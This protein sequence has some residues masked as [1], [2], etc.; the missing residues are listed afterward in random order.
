[1]RK[2]LLIAASALAASVISSQASVYSQNIVGYVNYPM[3]QGSHNYF[4]S[5]PFAIGV[6][7]GANEIFGT[8]PPSGSP[9]L[10]AGTAFYFY[11]GF[12]FD[13]ILYDVDPLG[14]GDTTD[15]WYMSNDSTPTNAPVLPVGMGFLMVPSG[16]ITNTWAGAVAINVGSQT[17]I[18]FPTGSKNYFVGCPVPYGGSLSNGLA[19]GGGP[20][21]NNLPLG[22]ALYFY[23]GF[24]FDETIYDND[25]LGTGDTDLWYMSNDSTPTNPPNITPGQAFLFVPSGPYTWTV[26]L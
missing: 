16:A 13:E 23:N 9:T 1:M 25:P 10:P 26:G 7:N 18:T 6:S 5:I 15:F 8:V 12:G 20:N 17:T 2:T 3:P 11:N 24:G 14:T 4:V 22:S 21:F 19:S